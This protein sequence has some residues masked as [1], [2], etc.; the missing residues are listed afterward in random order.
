M[1]LELKAWLSSN[2][3]VS[4]SSVAK[5]LG[6]SPATINLYLKHEYR[7]KTEEL[8]KKVESFCA[9]KRSVRKN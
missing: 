5:A 3:N 9:S 7:G 1:Y 8:D 6:V 4:Q 2:P